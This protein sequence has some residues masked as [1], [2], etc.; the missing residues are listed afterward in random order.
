MKSINNHLSIVISVFVLLFALQFTILVKKVVDE[1]A[2]KLVNDYS[3]VVVAS[4]ELKE[5][6]FK[7]EISEVYGIEE[8]DSK[9]ILDRLKNEMPS[10]NLGMLQAALPKFYSLKLEKLPDSKKL[11]SIKQKLEAHSSITRVETFVKTHDK[12]FKMFLLLRSMVYVFAAFVGCI[13]VFLTFKQ[14]RIW[15]Y[16]HS[17]RMSIMS[18][19]GASF[20]MKSAM[21]YRMTLVDSLIGAIL[22]CLFYM[23]MPKL[24]SVKAFVAEFD[25]VLPAFDPLTEGTMLI[26]IALLF[27]IISVSFVARKVV[28]T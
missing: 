23:V 5:E 16:E 9:R 28:R 19:F 15:M 22:V 1:Y 21:L 24:E 4:T 12:V 20:F 8:I 11:E 13:A 2:V 17:K 10:K 7:K 18:L 3:I 25:V 27:A 6:S 26:V 14:V